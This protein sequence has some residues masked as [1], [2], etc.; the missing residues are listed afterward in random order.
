M[1]A[2]AAATIVAIVLAAA[3]A[4]VWSLVAQALIAP[5]VSAP[6][7]TVVTHFRPKLRLSMRHFRDLLGYG[8]Q[9]VLLDL[10]NFANRRGDDLLIGAVLGPVALGYYSLAY[11]LLLLLTD[12]L[13]STVST[14]LLPIV[15]SLQTD[16]ARTRDIFYKATRV[17]AA[18][19]FP[20]F[21]FTAIAAS[22]LVLLLYGGQ[23]SAAVPAVR[24]F[25]LI[26]FVHTLL[27]QFNPVFNGLGKP[28]ATVVITAVNAVANIAA[29]A[30]GLQWGFVG[31]AAAY[32]IRG[33]LFAPMHVWAGKRIFDMRVGVWLNQWAWPVGAVAISAA[34][35]ALP[36]LLLDEHSFVGLLV[37]SAVM[38]ST[39]ILSL[40]T[41]TPTLAREFG[42]HVRQALR[43]AG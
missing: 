26:G 22:P 33:F 32:V 16:L 27:Y 5:A 20:G 1:L 35:A 24:L 19:A 7:L 28:R 39:Y 10:L 4:G 11:R 38:A 2:A 30:I 42:S 14:V 12:L 8:A 15:G 9:M 3:G 41:L 25:M 23:W 36:I 29:F 40:R 18:L 21:A 17:G 34:A 43:S 31:V 37:A 13:V 6:A